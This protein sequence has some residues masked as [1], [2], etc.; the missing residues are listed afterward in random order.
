MGFWASRA[1]W[2]RGGRRGQ[3]RPRLGATPRHSGAQVRGQPRQR[4]LQRTREGQYEWPAGAQAV[5]ATQQQG[6]HARGQQ[7][8]D[9]ASGAGPQ[10]GP[11][12]RLP[13]APTRSSMRHVCTDSQQQ[14]EPGRS[15]GTLIEDIQHLRDVE[16][17]ATFGR[18]QRTSRQL[19]C[20]SK[21]LASS[22]SDFKQLPDFCQYAS[23]ASDTPSTARPGACKGWLG[24]STSLNA[25]KTRL[26]PDMA[27][28][29]ARVEEGCSVF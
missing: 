29:L 18:P 13:D 2:V 11:R 9:P 19:V 22:G 24:H 26:R 23:S 14:G 16:A 25:C 20:P 1:C 15:K 27:D 5:V 28:P 8:Q 17:R 6:A 12:L 10:A 7:L 21:E 4:A 3:A